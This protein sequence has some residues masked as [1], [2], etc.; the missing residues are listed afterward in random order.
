[1]GC[2][3]WTSEETGWGFWGVGGLGDWKR[4][5]EVGLYL[6]NICLH[7]QFAAVVGSTHGNL[8]SK[9]A[10]R[11]FTPQIRGI[12]WSGLKEVGVSGLQT[13]A[14]WFSSCICELVRLF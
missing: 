4:R 5:I 9:K 1:M 3:S 12:F 8:K 13:Y 2:W 14:S 6:G 10:L 11:N 7:I